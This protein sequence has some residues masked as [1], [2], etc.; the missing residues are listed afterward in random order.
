MTADTTIMM[1]TNSIKPTTI[2][3]LTPEAYDDPGIRNCPSC[4][5]E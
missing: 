4:F 1:M 3:R 2:R 5:C